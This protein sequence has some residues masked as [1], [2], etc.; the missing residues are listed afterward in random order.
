MIQRLYLKE[1]LSFNEVELE[2]QKGLI[3][4]SGPSG[5][6]KSILMEAILAALGMAEAKAS[7]GELEVSWY[8]DEERFG[9]VNEA[10]NIVRHVKKEKVRYFINAQSFSKR[11]ISDL[12]QEYLKHLSLRDYSDFENERLLGLLDRYCMQDNP[13][14]ANLLKRY[15]ANFHDYGEA[16]KELEAIEDQE[17]HIAELK[18]FARF[19]V[20]KIEKIAPKIGE[21][22]SLLQIKKTLSRREKI[23]NAITQAQRLFEMESHVNEALELLDV[24]AAFFDET[25]NELR[26]IFDASLEQMSELDDVDIESV[27]DRIETLSGLK[28]RYG[29]L[30]EAL[31]YRDKKAQ[32]LEAYEQIEVNKET[33]LK[34]VKSLYEI[35]EREATLISQA[36]HEAIPRFEK[37]LNHYLNALYL[38]DAALHVTPCAHGATGIDIVEI[39]LEATPMQQLSSGEFN[40]LRLALLAL[41]AEFIEHENGV[42]MLD[43]I[44]A[45][46]SGE[47]SMSVA[48][49]LREL[50]RVYQIFVI[51]HQPQLTSMGMQHFFVSKTIHSS[52]RELEPQERVQEIARMIS[53]EHVSD[54]AKNFAKELLESAQC[55]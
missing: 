53:G 17:R 43:E 29:T 2:F 34:R 52:V 37:Q 45:N 27:L 8:F 54:E 25:M 49:V 39:V 35:I 47:E 24:D 22:E 44:D 13:D 23:E 31:Q 9:V 21:D 46:L 14:F 42:L 40:R 51:S 20:Q 26:A 1:M 30:E 16:K 3:V 15:Q 7:L 32:E 6:G 33:L 36:R 4:F 5:S 11:S 38:R 19:E 10:P 48:K 12:A 55:V 18:E 28:H 50:S 41:H